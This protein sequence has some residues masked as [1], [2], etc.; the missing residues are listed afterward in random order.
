LDLKVDRVLEAIEYTERDQSE[1]QGKDIRVDALY[2]GFAA[3][4]ISVP[5][6]LIPSG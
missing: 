1:L 2:I 3:L 5:I 4:A 6:L